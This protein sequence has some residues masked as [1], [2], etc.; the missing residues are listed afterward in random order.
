M[1]GYGSTLDA[2]AGRGAIEYCTIDTSVHPGKSYTV[3]LNTY[4]VPLDDGLLDYALAIVDG[5]CGDIGQASGGLDECLLLAESREV[6]DL[7]TPDGDFAL[8]EQAYCN[9]DIFQF[10]SN[11]PDLCG[12]E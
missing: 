1:P 8:L 5:G 9:G 4:S 10:C 12:E 3:V 6:N 7:D 2:H 11:N